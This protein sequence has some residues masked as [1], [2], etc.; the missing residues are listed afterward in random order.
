MVSMTRALVGCFRTKTSKKSSIRDLKWFDSVCRSSSCQ[1]LVIGTSR[2]NSLLSFCFP[3]VWD[4]DLNTEASCS[5]T[6][7]I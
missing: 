7:I 2:C 1:S 5:S 4:W 6:F 3:P